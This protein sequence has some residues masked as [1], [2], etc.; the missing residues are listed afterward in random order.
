MYRILYLRYAAKL[1]C[2]LI[3]SQY[4]LLKDCS[5]NKLNF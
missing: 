1:R 5:A 3:L 2:I 4:C